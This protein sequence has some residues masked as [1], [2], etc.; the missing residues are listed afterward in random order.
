MNCMFG[1]RGRT[2]NQLLRSH[3]DPARQDLPTRSNRG[4]I[5]F[6]VSEPL[7]TL[8]LATAGLNR[9]YEPERTLTQEGT[10]EDEATLGISGALA[11]PIFP[12]VTIGAETWY[13]RHYAE[14]ELSSFTGDAVVAPNIYV[15]VTSKAFVT[16][17]W[18]TQ[19]TGHEI[20]AT[21]NPDLTDF[22]RNR[23]KIK[24]SNDDQSPP[25]GQTR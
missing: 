16:F 11:Y 8:V 12:N 10:A 14:I 15:R 18:N 17:A 22:Y 1:S 13:L 7:A 3:T 24:A 2:R 19:I 5:R 20:G 23:F 25:R 21:G 9:L 4:S 6:K